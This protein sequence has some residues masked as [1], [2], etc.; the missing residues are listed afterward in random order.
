ML[1]RIIGIDHDTRYGLRCRGLCCHSRHSTS[2]AGPRLRP[3]HCDDESVHR[4]SVRT[5]DQCDVT[6]ASGSHIDD[7]TIAKL[8]TFEIISGAARNERYDFRLF[9]TTWRFNYKWA[10]VFCNGECHQSWIHVRDDRLS[11]FRN[12]IYGALNYLVSD[13]IINWHAQRARRKMSLIPSALPNVILVMACR[14][15]VGILKIL[16][17]DAMGPEEITNIEIYR[18][19]F[20][21]KRHGFVL[22]V[23]SV[24]TGSVQVTHCAVGART[25]HGFGT[26]LVRNPAIWLVESQDQVN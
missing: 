26:D 21:L 5:I 25:M 7:V 15:I 19:K 24:N 17:H 2:K 20:I 14:W 22:H 3:A 23:T 6:I 12:R 18:L 8:L 13:V 16:K 10:V 4:Y 1:C 9:K 11:K